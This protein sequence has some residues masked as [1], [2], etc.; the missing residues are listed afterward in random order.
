M[1]EVEHTCSI[2]KV[3]FTG[4]GHNPQ[5]LI[6][7]INQRCCDRC[8]KYV[9]SSRVVT[10]GLVD[11]FVGNGLEEIVPIMYDRIG[12]MLIMSHNLMVVSEKEKEM[13]AKMQKEVK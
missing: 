13:I 11:F 2:C 10:R 6:E 5:P 9:T 1:S 12:K 8:N 4:Y 7:D 3:K